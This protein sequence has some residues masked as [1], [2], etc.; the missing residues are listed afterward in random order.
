MLLPP[1]LGSTRGGARAQLNWEE[2]TTENERQYPAATSYRDVD[3]HGD[4]YVYTLGWGLKVQLAEQLAQM[5]CD[6]HQCGVVHRDIK[7]ANVLLQVSSPARC[8]G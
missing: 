4:V 2:L 3:D 5:L 7:A 1:R 6:L 8:Q